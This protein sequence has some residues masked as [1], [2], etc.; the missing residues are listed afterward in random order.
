MAKF[1][2][3]LSLENILAQ[4]GLIQIRPPTLELKLILFKKR[5]AENQY[6]VLIKL[7]VVSSAKKTSETSNDNKKSKLFVADSENSSFLY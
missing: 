3:D 1:I 5:A 6:E 7:S 2:R 4:K